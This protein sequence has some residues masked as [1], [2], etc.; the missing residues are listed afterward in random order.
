[1]PNIPF[2]DVPSLPGV[3]SI[4]RSASAPPAAAAVLGAIA[5]VL[6]RAFQVDT[7][8]GI[9]DSRGRPLAGTTGFSFVESLGVTNATYSTS[10][11]DFAKEMRVSDF[12]LELGQF[13]SY[14]K[15]ELPASPLVTLCMTGSEAQRTAFLAAIDK[16]C[17]S[18]DLYTVATPEVKYAGYS[19][20]SYRYSRHA[21]GGATLLMVEISLKEVRQVSAQLA[22]VQQPKAP[23]AAPK[24]D[25][26]K[27]QAPAPD[28]STL[29]SLSK[30]L[31]IGG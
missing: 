18:T 19:L 15:V 28:V 1:M 24:V 16:A 10:G 26:G 9:F 6:W 30:K 17:K 21:S 12:P 20:E 5:G 13:A 29:K 7:R 4:P 8:W 27:V 14:N 3:P 23:S 11:L 25:A 31:G 22:T 2:P